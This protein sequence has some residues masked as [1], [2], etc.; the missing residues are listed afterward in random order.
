MKHGIRI[1]DR[2]DKSSG[3]GILITEV[4]VKIYPTEPLQL[5]R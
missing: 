3:T 5:V 2:E 4:F 1:K